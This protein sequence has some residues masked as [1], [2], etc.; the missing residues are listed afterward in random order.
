MA[1]LPEKVILAPVVADGAAIPAGNA[2]HVQAVLA[3]LPSVAVAVMVTALDVFF[4]IAS[5][6]TSVE[7][8]TGAFS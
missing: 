1:S 2:V 7:K 3:L 4:K 6:V 5:P 8:D